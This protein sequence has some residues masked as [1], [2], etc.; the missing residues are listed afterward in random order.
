MNA[1]TQIPEIATVEQAI[2]LLGQLLARLLNGQKA[3]M[4]KIIA[5][6]D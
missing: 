5:I 3:Y 1:N 4:T 2:A 6:I